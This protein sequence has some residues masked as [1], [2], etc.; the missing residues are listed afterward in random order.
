[1][2]APWY[3]T[4]AEQRAE[5]AWELYHANAKRSRGGGLATPRA[6]GGPTDYGGFPALA[7]DA[8]RSR[9]APTRVARPPRAGSIPLSAFSEMLAASRRTAVADPVETFVFIASVDA[10]PRGLAWYDPGAH[11]LRLL[12][13]VE[14]Q[15]L[16]RA[17][18]TPEVARRA[19]VLIALAV[20]FDAAT[21]IGGERGY[22]E[23]LLDAGR[24]LAALSAAAETA[25]LGIDDAVGFYDREMDALLFLDGLARS[26]V[27][28]AA[29]GAGG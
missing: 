22:R 13:H 28:V 8:S 29:V 7:L 20:N 26:T 5:S 18:V 25:G 9:A 10:L 3:D 16:E 4:A 23:A 2:A 14:D 21:A 1:M 17:L 27:A 24:H 19:G 6:G 11:R 15:Q 12:S